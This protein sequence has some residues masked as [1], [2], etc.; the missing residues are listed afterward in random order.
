[1]L[2]LAVVLGAMLSACG[3]SDQSPD[4]YSLE[5]KVAIVNAGH[6]VSADDLS[7]NRIRYLLGSLE[8]STG[9]PRDKIADQV[10]AARDIIRKN[11]GKEVSI[12]ELLEAANKAEAV[13]TKAVKLEEYLALYATFR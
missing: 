3:Q 12:L 2:Y 9:Y 5:Q 11:Y 4:S 7:V 10:A 6:F 1:M 13:R 8:A